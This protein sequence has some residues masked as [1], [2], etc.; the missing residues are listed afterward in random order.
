MKLRKFSSGSLIKN[1]NLKYAS[2]KNTSNIQFNSHNSQIYLKLPS[3]KVSS[4]ISLNK[5]AITTSNLNFKEKKI[6]FNY[7]NIN[8]SHKSLISKSNSDLRFKTDIGI[9]NNSPNCSMNI[10]SNKNNKIELNNK[11]KIRSLSKNFSSRN[12]DCYA[13]SFEILKISNEEI[14]SNKNFKNNKYNNSLKANNEMKLFNLVKNKN[15]FNSGKRI[16]DNCYLKNKNYNKDKYKNL[17][18]LLSKKNKLKNQIT[19]FSALLDKY[20]YDSA[21]I[22]LYQNDKENIN[23]NNNLNNKNNIKKLVNSNHNIST[24]KNKRNNNNMSLYLDFHYKRTQPKHSSKKKI[25]LPVHP[26]SKIIKPEKGNITEI[27]KYFGKSKINLTENNI[28]FDNKLITKIQRQNS[29]KFLVPLKL[30]KRD[31]HKIIN[32]NYLN[33]INYFSEKSYRKNKSKINKRIKSYTDININENNEY[34]DD[35]DYYDGVE[36]GHFKI[37]RIIQKNKKKIFEKNE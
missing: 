19:N 24:H 23:T 33:E 35:I 7:N 16:N 12:F 8:N 25:N 11:N 29:T 30:K 3:K 5:K 21:Y 37:V 22:N 14:F 1:K 10:F 20:L 32:D 18:G 17:C 27:N 13:K 31:N 15:S 28:I 34:S 4:K 2:N 36:M 9:Y 6:K 26:K